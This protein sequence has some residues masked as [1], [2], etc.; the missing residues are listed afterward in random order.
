MNVP[1]VKQNSLVENIWIYIKINPNV[2]LS[3][4]ENNIVANKQTTLN[5][6]RTLLTTMLSAGV[7]TKNVIDKTKILNVCDIFK[8]SKQ[9]TIFVSEYRYWEGQKENKFLCGHFLD[10]EIDTI[11]KLRIEIFLETGIY[12][13]F[14]KLFLQLIK[15]HYD[16]ITEKKLIQ[17]EHNLDYKSK[18]YPIELV[19]KQTPMEKLLNFFKSMKFSYP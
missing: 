19:E 1:A 8:D 13:R 17:I 3:V 14:E 18:V 11:N 2:E 12:M 16:S 15:N 9:A 7:I 6:V 4:L 5:T 10:S